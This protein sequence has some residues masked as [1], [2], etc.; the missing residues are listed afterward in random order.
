MKTDRH[1]RY[2]KILAK[3]AEAQEPVARMRLTAAL[4]Y[5]NEIIS[6]G[7]NQMKTHPFQ[8]KFAKNK[9]SIYLHAEVNCVRN[10]LRSVSMDVIS[11]CTMYVYR[12][13]H[14]GQDSSVFIPGLSK[15]CEGCQR[16]IAEFGIKRVAYSL[17]NEG[18]DWL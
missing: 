15:P 11:R 10:A 7:C 6:V 9:E 13:K 18:Y 3:I 8:M 5:K 17:D 4:V 1:Q 14:P 12:A 16:C 2:M